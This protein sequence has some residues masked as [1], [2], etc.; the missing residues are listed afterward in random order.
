VQ[1]EHGTYYA[2][3]FNWKIEQIAALAPDLVFD[4][5]QQICRYL[6][7]AGIPAVWTPACAFN[8]I[9]PEAGE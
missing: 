6:N 1:Q 9:T 8:G 3:Y 5:D 4:D 7:R 2:R